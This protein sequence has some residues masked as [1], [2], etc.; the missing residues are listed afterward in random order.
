MNGNK[1]DLGAVGKRIHRE[2]QRLGNIPT[3]AKRA[4]PSLQLD[5]TRI[6]TGRLRK[7]LDKAC[8][9]GLDPGLALPAILACASACP[10]TLVQDGTRINLYVCLLATSGGGKDTAIER[11]LKVFWPPNGWGPQVEE[12]SAGG[13]KQIMVLL[14]PAK[15]AKGEQPQPGPRHTLIV[16]YE[17]GDALKKGA[18]DG[19]SLLETMC[20]LYG[21]PRKFLDSR[22]R[23]KI[24]VDCVPSWLMALPVGK[25]GNIQ[26][27]KFAE[28]FGRGTTD[29][30]D[31]RTIFGFSEE[32]IDRR[33]SRHW[34]PDM[35]ET[36]TSQV[37]GMEIECHGENLGQELSRAVVEGWEPDV[38]KEFLAWDP[39]D[40]TSGRAT[41]HLQKVA[42][43]VAM[44]NGHKRVGPDD[45]EAAK[46]VMRVQEEIRKVFCASEA[47]NNPSAKLNETIM[48]A[49]ERR[50][51]KKLAVG[52]KP[53]ECWVPWR[54]EANHGKWERFGPPVDKAMDNLVNMGRLV[55]QKDEDEN[56]KEKTDK[57]YVMTTAMWSRGG[58]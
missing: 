1:A 24:L 38:E 2:L 19:S 33:P 58:D 7:I 20:W 44:L 4:Y 16:T 36:T 3:E 8:E 18:A 6:G 11:A 40:E 35:P 26:P 17:L 41:Y 23:E 55:Y 15:P 5:L 54:T 28:A 14:G 45:F 39:G 37:D 56:G 48:R 47:E 34:K 43:L 9:G 21:K 25:R 49:V 31:S 10:E 42:I 22:T 32:S 30:L 52:K 57:R 46:E 53:R 50:E 12:V 29:G 51:S 27:E 13:D